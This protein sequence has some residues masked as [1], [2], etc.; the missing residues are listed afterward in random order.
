[1]KLVFYPLVL[2]YKSTIMKRTTIAA[3]MLFM[4]IPMLSFAQRGH[5]KKNVRAKHHAKKVVYVKN[6]HYKKVK[7]VKYKMP[8]RH[9]IKQVPAWAHA[10][11]FRGYN[12]VYFPDYQVFYDAYRGG[13]VYWGRNQWLFSRRVPAFMARVNLNR[14]R[15]QVLNDIDFYQRPERYY[16]N[17]R[18]RYA[19]IQVNINLNGPRF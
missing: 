10:H 5:H 18:P 16:S 6:G 8:K 14:A 2:N 15:I 4:V 9:H 1:I 11:K 17:I 7:T 13:Y 3:L 12:H 19:P